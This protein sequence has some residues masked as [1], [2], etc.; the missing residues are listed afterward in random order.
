MDG[1]I[2]TRCQVIVRSVLVLVRASLI[3]LASGLIVI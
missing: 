2:A 3:T 1:R